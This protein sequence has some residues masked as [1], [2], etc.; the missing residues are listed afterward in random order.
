VFTFSSRLGAPSITTAVVFEAILILLFVS[1]C[2]SST[3]WF[4]PTTFALLLAVPALSVC[5]LVIFLSIFVSATTRH[6][7]PLYLT[8]VP[9]AERIRHEPPRSPLALR[10]PDMLN[11]VSDLQPMPAKPIEYDYYNIA[12]PPNAAF[13]ETYGKIQVESPK[14]SVPAVGVLEGA[15]IISGGLILF[16]VVTYGTY[17]L[18]CFIIDKFIAPE[19][20]AEKAEIST[21]EPEPVV[22]LIPVEPPVE[23]VD[24]HLWTD[25]FWSYIYTEPLPE[26]SGWMWARM[27]DLCVYGVGCYL[28]TYVAA[29]FM[30]E[31]R[32]RMFKSWRRWYAKIIAMVRSSSAILVIWGAKVVPR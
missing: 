19:E 6:R 3:I 22:E 28:S 32:E 20:L 29:M 11:Y 30:P 14:P 9:P 15:I 18:S 25:I 1:T 12:T 21:V 13:Y 5:E 4:E 27:I 31:E 10:R 8:M 26:L 23:E 17:W 7:Y 2:I 16:G 24:V